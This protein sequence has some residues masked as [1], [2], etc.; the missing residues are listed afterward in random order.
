[1]MKHPASAAESDLLPGADD[2]T[3]YRE[4]GYWVSPPVLDPGFI[5]EVIAATERFYSGVVDEG[6]PVPDHCLPTGAYTDDIRKHDYASLH[7]AALARLVRE[8]LIGAM[9]ARL[10]GTPEIRLWH[11]QLIYKPAEVE[12]TFSRI[13]WHTDRQYW[14]TCSSSNMI[15][16]WVPF[17]DTDE[18]VGTLVMLDGSHRWSHEVDA[19][20]TSNAREQD[21]TSVEARLAATGHEL[22]KVSLNLAKGQVSFHH[23]ATYHGSGGNHTDRPRRSISIH[24]QDQ[25]N[26]YAAVRTRD[27]SLAAHPVD[28]LCRQVEGAPD[29]TD[30]DYFPVLWPSQR[31]RTAR[32]D[33]A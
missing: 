15:T 20:C 13:G 3:F 30:P 23:M 19:A 14:T 8:P 10:A 18:D 33:Q 21:M 27:G 6:P 22:R 7:C 25:V 11:D 17:H 31:E 16:A 26:R 9:A 32:S 4:H 2:V 28:A 1:M 5:D 12:G 29:Y 24:L